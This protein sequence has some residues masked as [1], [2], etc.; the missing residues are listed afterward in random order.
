MIEIKLQKHSLKNTLTYSI[1]VCYSRRFSG[2]KYIEKIG[3]YKPFINNFGNKYVFVNFNRLLF[4]IL[5][6]AKINIM[7]FSLIKPLLILFK[8]NHEN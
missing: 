4:W 3:F 8:K 2:K 5:K 1:I 6:G 7:V